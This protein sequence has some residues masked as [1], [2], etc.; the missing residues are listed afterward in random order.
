MEELIAV[1]RAAHKLG[2]SRHELQK[3]IRIGELQTFEGRLV[4][5]ELREHF[6]LM[7]MDDSPMLERVRNIKATAFSRRVVERVAPSSDDIEIQLK[8]KTLDLDMAKTEAKRYREIL[9][10]MAKFLQ[11]GQQSGNE[12][13][14]EVYMSLNHWLSERL[15]K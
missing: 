11:S 3:L 15:N 9:E 6:P 10:D 14:H 8:R 13:E 12:V 4:V 5:S 7:S 1:A 2:I